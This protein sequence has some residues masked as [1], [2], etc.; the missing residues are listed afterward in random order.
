MFHLF[1][2]AIF[3]GHEIIRK[4]FRQDHF[5]RGRLS[6]PINNTLREKVCSIGDELVLYI[7]RL[8]MTIEQTLSKGLCLDSDDFW[9]S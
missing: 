9:V 6:F 5:S 8:R 1:N 7:E 2:A 4:S 3:N